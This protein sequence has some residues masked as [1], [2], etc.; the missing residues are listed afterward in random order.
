VSCKEINLGNGATAWICTR[1]PREYCKCGSGLPVS[2]LCDFELRGRKAGSTCSWKMCERCT[3]RPEGT[4]SDYCQAHARLVEGWLTISGMAEAWGV[5]A[6]EVESVMVVVG[7][8]D[9][10]I[11]GHGDGSGRLW[12]KEVQGLV[13]RELDAMKLDKE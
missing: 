7:V 2:R 12:S 10:K 8:R 11:H 4:E 9:S 6:R 3:T 5:E 13:K 1:G